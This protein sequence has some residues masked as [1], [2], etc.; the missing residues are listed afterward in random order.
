MSKPTTEILT[1]PIK[2]RKTKWVSAWVCRDA[3][4]LV[5]VLCGPRRDIWY[6]DRGRWQWRL[7]VRVIGKASL[8]MANR[9]GM[10]PAPG[11]CVRARVEI[12]ED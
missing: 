6:G 2:R 10:L 5:F 3:D 7:A 9:S 8:D 12:I 11:K 4:G 1:I